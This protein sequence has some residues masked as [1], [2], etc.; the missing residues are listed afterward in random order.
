LANE[1]NAPNAGGCVTDDQRAVRSVGSDVSAERQYSIGIRITAD[2]LIGLLVDLNGEVV[3][4]KVRATDAETPGKVVRHRP[5]P[6]TGVD[7]VV[8][9][10]AGLAAELL[11]IRPEF[12]AK[13]IGLGVSIG[14]HVNGE[15]GEVRYSPHF[16]WNRTIPLAQHLR[17]ATSMNLVV[18]ENDVNALAGAQ[19]WFGRG[20]RYQRF[21]VV[22]IGSGIGCGLFINSELERG[23]S[24][25]A[26]ELGHIPSE[27]E[28]ERCTC[29]KRG[30]LQTV[31]G[32]DA[33]VRAL[34]GAGQS[35]IRDIQAAAGLVLGGDRM[36]REVFH[37]AGEAL[38]RG[39]ATLLNLLNLEA[40]GLCGE[41]AIL[42]SGVYL[43]TVR[44]A[45]GRHAF[46]TAADDCDLWIEERTD[47]LEARGA[48]SM[49]FDHLVD[50]REPA[51][52]G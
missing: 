12:R 42:S 16:G 15:T 25:L 28:G 48:A 32:S 43:D 10:V 27:P 5:L 30:C 26:G 3:D 29:G 34:Q 40:I 21:A 9:S 39:L 8:S 11:A 19:Q 45:L 52:E 4:L 20:G 22:K 37:R 7:A 23:K 1:P 47:E 24:G 49:V 36:A 2:Q 50:L 6:G 18:L 13:A 33:I 41:P 51:T 38:G 44:E 35:E 14:G 17:E 46:S 31:A